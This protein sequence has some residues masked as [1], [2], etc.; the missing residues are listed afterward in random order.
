LADA[1][2][3]RS[4]ASRCQEPN[5]VQGRGHPDLDIGCDPRKPAKKYAALGSRDVIRRLLFLALVVIAIGFVHRRRR[6]KQTAD[7]SAPLARRTTGTSTA[8]VVGETATTTH[9]RP[10]PPTPRRD[11]PEKP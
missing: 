9:L 6:R 8:G 7:M 2:P 4:A 11:E 3:S 1:D 10:A 5:V